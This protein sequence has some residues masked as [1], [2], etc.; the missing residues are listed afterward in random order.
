[1]RMM[2]FICAYLFSGSR[3]PQATDNQTGRR[4]AIRRLLQ[5]GPQPNQNRLVRSLRKL[6]LDATQSSV[7][8]DLKDLGAIK[9]ARG[10]ELP[11]T[12]TRTSA[13]AEPRLGG[14]ADLLRSLTPAGPNLLVV[15]TAV[16]AAQRVA[17]AFD[18][19]EWT[20]IV[21]T[22]AGDDTVFV[23]TENLRGQRSVINRLQ[24]HEAIRQQFPETERPDH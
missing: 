18:Q 13:I 7:S 22:V 14:V 19:S 23:A 15:R 20:D 5:R 9:T 6:G 8:R 10:Y 21:G 4:D 11:T 24:H 3:V 1:M 2:L 16:G 12:E 17:L